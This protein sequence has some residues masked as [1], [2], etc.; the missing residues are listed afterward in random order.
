MVQRKDGTRNR[1][2]RKALTSKRFHSL[3]NIRQPISLWQKRS[4][5]AW[6]SVSL[7]ASLKSARIAGSRLSALPTLAARVPKFKA[8]GLEEVTS[9]NANEQGGSEKGHGVKASKVPP[10]PIDTLLDV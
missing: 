10:G 6:L 8:K 5:G 4:S 2:V 3:P 1:L 9:P 7:V